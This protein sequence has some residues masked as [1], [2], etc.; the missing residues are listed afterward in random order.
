MVALTMFLVDGS[1]G[2]AI[3]ALATTFVLSHL[4][5]GIRLKDFSFAASISEGMKEVMPR[6]MRSWLK[7]GK[8]QAM[9]SK[10]IMNVLEE[11]S[12]ASWEVQI[13]HTEA[14]MLKPGASPSYLKAQFE[15][16]KVADVLMR[17]TLSAVQ[18]SLTFQTEPSDAEINQLND[19]RD[20]LHLLERE[21]R[22]LSDMSER[23]EDSA[24]LQ[25]SLEHFRALKDAIEEVKTDTDSG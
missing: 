1:Y 9:L 25:D 6:R 12:K 15:A 2:L 10:D 19:L 7:K 4:A 23:A 16:F 11:C 22:T 20:D 8:L 17:R 3:L 21:S 5:E 24:D 13:S 14:K 18:R